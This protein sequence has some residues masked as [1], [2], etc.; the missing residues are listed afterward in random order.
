MPEGVD[1]RIGKA[2]SGGALAGMLDRAVDPLKAL[3]GEDAVVTEALD[4]EQP[5][6]G[7][8]AD[9]AQFGQVVQSFADGE[10]VG[11]VDRCFGAQRA[12]FFV[13]LLDPGA[14]VIDV[15]GGRDTLGEDAGAQ[16]SRGAA[17]N[18]AVKDQLDLIEPAEIEV[19]T[20][21]LFE[22]QPAV[23][24]AIEHLGE[25]KLGLQ[26]RDVVAI[27]GPSIGLSKRVRQAARAASC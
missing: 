25:G 9:V 24:R 10:V 13:I 18:P 20:D 16:P 2:Q 19:L 14:L 23:H 12:L 15:Q 1:A 22:K 11:V 4:F 21:H 8:E 27:P 3:L 6:V 7:A 26:D 17:G 5:A